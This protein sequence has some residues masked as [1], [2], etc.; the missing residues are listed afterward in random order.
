M[1]TTAIQIQMCKR[2][3]DERKVWTSSDW[4]EILVFLAQ[5]CGMVGAAIMLYS[6]GPALGTALIGGSLVAWS[7]LGNQSRDAAAL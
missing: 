6:V 1:A 3:T 4:R 7:L 5:A 2:D